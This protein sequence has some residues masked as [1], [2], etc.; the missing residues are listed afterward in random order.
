M[1]LRNQA[2]A[3]AAVAA[4]GEA[5]NRP[6]KTFRPGRPE[7]R[8]PP[9]E[10]RTLFAMLFALP[11][12][13][14]FVYAMVLVRESEME[15]M[16]RMRE[17]SSSLRRAR[18]AR[19]VHTAGTMYMSAQKTLESTGL[20]YLFGSAFSKTQMDWPSSFD[21]FHQRRPTSNLP[22]MFLTFQKSAASNRMT[23]I[24]RRM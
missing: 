15:T 11:N 6:E 4:A 3:S 1:Y 14:H 10:E 5:P 16:T 7:K 8:E 12:L 21:S 24:K 23:V 20:M 18:M 22:E 9:T 19:K 17:S 13:S 2:A